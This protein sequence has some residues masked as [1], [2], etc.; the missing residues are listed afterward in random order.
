[1][2]L[3]YYSEGINKE[4]KKQKAPSKSKLSKKLKTFEIET[5]AFYPV[6]LS[7]KAS[8]RKQAMLQLESMD[9]WH[10]V[11]QDHNLN[12]RKLSTF[13]IEDVKEVPKKTAKKRKELSRDQIDALY[14]QPVG[15]G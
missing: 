5:Y 14:P 13:Y 3:K 9:S 15:T 12:G 4:M 6:R 10:D 1:L 11:K 2:I 7:I 8:S